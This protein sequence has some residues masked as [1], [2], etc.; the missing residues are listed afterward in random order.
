M[1][2]D[3]LSVRKKHI[4][5]IIVLW[6]NLGWEPKN[7]LPPN[8]LW[9]VM[10]V[11]PHAGNMVKSVQFPCLSLE[12]QSF[13]AYTNPNIHHQQKHQHFKSWNQYIYI[14]NTYIY[15]IHNY[16]SFLSPFFPE[17]PQYFR[18]SITCCRCFLAAESS[19]QQMR[20]P[21]QAD[22]VRQRTSSSWRAAKS[23]SK[24]P[25]WRFS[26][27]VMADGAK[28]VGLTKMWFESS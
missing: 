22:Q 4:S 14:Y 27:W 11:N 24:P 10:Q 3:K 13:H 18:T 16:M 20:S 17:I 6:H 23:T 26:N 28:D 15:I 19:P 1:Y 7:N 12:Y 5:T 21:A 8:R 25:A 2:K 9:L